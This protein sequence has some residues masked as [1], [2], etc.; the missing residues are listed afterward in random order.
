M[1]EYFEGQLATAIQVGSAM[2]NY[3]ASVEPG[4]PE[5]DEYMRVMQQ[6]TNKSSS[7]RKNEASAPTDET[8][9]AA[10]QGSTDAEEEEV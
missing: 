1:L 5:Y 7:A 6:M 3:I 4:T 10:A 9:E 8:Q 2:G